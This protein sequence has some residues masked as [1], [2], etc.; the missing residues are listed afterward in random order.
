MPPALFI[1][2]ISVLEKI[3][4]PLAVFFFLVL[5]FRVFGKRELGSIGPFDLVIWLTISNILQNAMIGP[6][7]SLSGG[8]I[9]ATTMFGANWLLARVSFYFPTFEQLVQGVP[10]VLI[11]N[12]AIIEKNLQKELLTIDDLR[13]ALRKNQVDLDEEL[14]FLRRV[15]F[16]SDGAITIT[17]RLPEERGFGKRHGKRGSQKT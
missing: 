17:R 9:G 15:M 12:G 6:D 16:E 10:T 11:D 13:H 3:I 2:E 7:N 1:P 14:P 5:A 8:L 4:R